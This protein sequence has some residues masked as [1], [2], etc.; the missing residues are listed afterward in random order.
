MIC[1]FGQAQGLLPC[2]GKIF[3]SP[4]LFSRFFW[5]RFGWAQVDL[6]LNTIVPHDPYPVDASVQALHETLLI[7]D[8]HADTMLW[9]RDFLA[10]NTHGHVDLPRLIEGNVALQVFATVTRSPS[11]LNYGQNHADAPDD[12]RLLA[13]AQFWPP[14]TWDSPLERALYQAQRLHGFAEA[15][16]GAFTVIESESDLDA[17]IEARSN[18]SPLVGGILGVRGGPRP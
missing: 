11:N 4:S 13:M 5:S 3:F 1:I 6:N 10:R 2:D 14:R 7:G 8:W 16:H 17:L 18:G 12:I 15:S 9:A